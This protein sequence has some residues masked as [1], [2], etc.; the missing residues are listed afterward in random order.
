MVEKWDTVYSPHV[1]RRR[2]LDSLSNI[3]VSVKATSCI[4]CMSEGKKKKKSYFIF[5]FFFLIEIRGIPFK[6][7]A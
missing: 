3:L 2:N 4:N 7:H 6:L 1:I 5:H